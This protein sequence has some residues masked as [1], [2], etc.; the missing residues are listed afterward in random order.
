MFYVFFEPKLNKKYAIVCLV[1]NAEI[2]THK[3]V[4]KTTGT[5]NLL[6]NLD[7]LPRDE[8]SSI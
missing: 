7:T 1:D 3:I 4:R 6:F 5:L 2:T 8:I